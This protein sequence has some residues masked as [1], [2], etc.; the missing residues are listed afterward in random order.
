MGLA[1]V[2]AAG[3]QPKSV[4]EALRLPAGQEVLYLV[5]VGRPK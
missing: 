1:G 4:A 5:P 3:F 2:P